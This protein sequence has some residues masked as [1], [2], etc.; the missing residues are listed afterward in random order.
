MGTQKVTPALIFAITVATIGSFQF[1]YNTGVINAP[2]KSVL[3]PTLL[4]CRS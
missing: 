4:F 1:G 2:E 3:P